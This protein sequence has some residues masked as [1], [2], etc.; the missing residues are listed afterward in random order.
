MRSLV[1]YTSQSIVRNEVKEEEMVRA[2]GM[3]RGEVKCHRS[4]VQKC[5]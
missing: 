1:A 2:C 3:C 5:E 4:L